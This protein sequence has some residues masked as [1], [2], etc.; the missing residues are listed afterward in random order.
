M[1]TLSPYIADLI[2]SEIQLKISL[3]G[4]LNFLIFNP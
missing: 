1:E 4:D 3:N 2:L